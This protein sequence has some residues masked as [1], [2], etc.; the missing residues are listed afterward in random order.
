MGLGAGGADGSPFPE[1][2]VDQRSDVLVI[3]TAGFI[4]NAPLEDM[5]KEIY[6]LP[7]CEQCVCTAVMPSARVVTVLSVSDTPE[8]KLLRNMKIVQ[9]GVM[10]H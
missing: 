6:T 4:K 3:D 1:R 5:G 8:S 9:G 2:D 10:V 7:V